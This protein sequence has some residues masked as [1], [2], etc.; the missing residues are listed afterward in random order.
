M[1]LSRGITRY[2]K[3]SLKKRISSLLYS[4]NKNSHCLLTFLIVYRLERC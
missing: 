1:I 3:K 2:K 4:N